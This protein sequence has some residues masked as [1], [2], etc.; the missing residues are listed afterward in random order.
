MVGRGTSG[1]LADRIARWVAIAVWAIDG[2]TAA[3]VVFWFSGFVSVV[4]D[5]DHVPF[6]LSQVLPEV[7]GNFA[8]ISSRFLHRPVYYVAGGICIGLGTLSAGW[9]MALVRK[10]EAETC[11]VH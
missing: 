2:L 6:A 9:A 3:L 5:V 8:G 10:L 4:L 11:Q 7:Y 1:Q